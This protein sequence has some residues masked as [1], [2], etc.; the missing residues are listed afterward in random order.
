MTVKEITALLEEQ[1]PLSFAED[2][3]NVGLLVGNATMEVTGILIT[4]DTLEEVV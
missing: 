1:A 4:L 3:D 2:F